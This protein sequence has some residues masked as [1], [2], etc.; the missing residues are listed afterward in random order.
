MVQPNEVTRDL[1]QQIIG[2]FYRAHAQKD[3]A[4][5]RTVVTPDWQY[6]PPSF[7]P[8]GGPDQMIPVFADLASALPDMDI[9]ILDLLI[10]GNLVGVRAKVRG[11]QSGSLMGIAATSKPIEFAIHSFHEFRDE[12]IAKTRHLEDWLSVFHQLGSLPPNLN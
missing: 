5:L 4:L 12:R 10:Y 2:R 3:V 1:A 8:A 11:T 9:Q 6:V 7:G